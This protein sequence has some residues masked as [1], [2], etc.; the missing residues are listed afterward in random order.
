MF[1]VVMIRVKLQALRPFTSF[2]YVCVGAH[3]CC[4]VVMLVLSDEKQNAMNP[5][6]RYCMN[7]A[8][9]LCEIAKRLSISESTVTRQVARLVGLRA[10]D[11]VQK[12]NSKAVSITLTGKILL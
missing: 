4:C 8:Q 2:M 7:P 3:S 1:S 6:I 12:G 9:P 5:R 10:L 11:L